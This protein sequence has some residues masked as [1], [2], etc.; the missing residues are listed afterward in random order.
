MAK[1][2][3]QKETEL[4]YLQEKLKAA[5]SVIFAGASKLTVSD[6]EGLRRSL[7][8]QG[9][10]VKVA[11]KRLLAL[12]LEKEGMPK[13]DTA[14]TKGNITL[15]FGI[16]DEVSPAK[17][18]AN[19]AKDNE[20]LVILGGILEQQYIDATRVKALAS[21]PSR[22]E[23]IAKT[24]GTIKAP[25]SGFVNVLAGNLRNFVYVLNAIKETKN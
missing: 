6:T 22:D 11:K 21:L 18:F 10:E 20:N 9:G 8:E 7:R 3:Q 23:L 5:K 2:R 19:F 17:V 15:A 1:T 13:A 25:I 4:Q 14:N 12:A 24:V 16:E